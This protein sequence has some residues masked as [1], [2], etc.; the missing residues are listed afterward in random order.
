LPS[1]V[2]LRMGMS[3]AEGAT[4]EG[5]IAKAV[6]EARVGETGGPVRVG[7]APSAAGVAPTPDEGGVASAASQGMTNR[8]RGGGRESRGG[9]ACALQQ[10]G[11]GDR[12]GKGIVGR[13]FLVRVE[14]GDDDTR[15]RG[16]HPG[17]RGGIAQ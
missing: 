2:R 8:G 15:R 10:S 17:G 11:T 16:S 12:D 14:R 9:S 1:G 7:V 13:D 6:G 5:E 3:E 4:T